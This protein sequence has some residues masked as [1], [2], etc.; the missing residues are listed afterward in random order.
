MKKI[1]IILSVLLFGF[2][3]SLTAVGQ[4]T[5]VP[6]ARPLQAIDMPLPAQDS[7]VRQVEHKREIARME[8]RAV[9]ARAAMRVLQQ[10][11][12]RAAAED[13][14]LASELNMAIQRLQKV[15][16]DT[17]AERPAVQP[18]YPLQYTTKESLNTER[19]KA[20]TDLARQYFYV[21]TTSPIEIPAVKESGEEAHEEIV[22]AKSKREE[23]LDN[24]TAC[25]KK[26][27]PAAQ[28]NLIQELIRSSHTNEELK[29][30]EGLLDE[31]CVEPGGDG[32]G[33]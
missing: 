23:I 27:S 6:V 20:Y 1:L 15:I 29:L 24:F 22:P 30:L 17:E 8:V 28:M 18:H 13:N 26:I 33:M 25:M 5:V 16:A 32:R 11:A 2:P 31:V 21:F 4:E 7:S 14:P 12:Q 10:I 9:Q 19:E 3:L